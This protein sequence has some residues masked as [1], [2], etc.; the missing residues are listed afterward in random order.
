[1][2]SSSNCMY[3]CC[4]RLKANGREK[5]VKV[6]EFVESLSS[7]WAVYLS[8]KVHAFSRKRI[9]RERQMRRSQ[10]K[11][12]ANVMGKVGAAESQGQTASDD[13][14]PEEES[15]V[16]ADAT[17]QVSM[18]PRIRALMQLQE[19]VQRK[20]SLA[21][22]KKNKAALLDQ[23]S[24]FALSQDGFPEI[25]AEAVVNT[26]FNLMEEATYGEFN[27]DAEPVKFLSK[28]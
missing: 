6:K 21:V 24:L 5:C 4:Q 1:M 28:K 8:S 16:E 13:D 23:L 19:G 3:R 7:Q 15:F 14:L 17:G 2:Y 26:M 27:F 12:T 20:E 25:A 11:P 18:A 10:S 9:Y 22:V